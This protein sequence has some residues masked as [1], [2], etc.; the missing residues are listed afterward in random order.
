MLSC[1]S[2]SFDPVN[3]EL[4]FEIAADES[5]SAALSNSFIS[6]FWAFAFSI[7]RSINFLISAES[8]KS[9]KVFISVFALS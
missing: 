7:A 2:K 9:K 4:T 3:D 1:D 5:K 6:A 8:V